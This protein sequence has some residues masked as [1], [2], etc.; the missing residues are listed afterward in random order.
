MGPR[1]EP[2][3]NNGEIM[4]SYGYG[5]NATVSEFFPS[6]CTGP[7]SFDYEGFIRYNDNPHFGAFSVTVFFLFFY[8]EYY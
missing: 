3:Q 2:E 8:E 5:V 7:R 4:P 6:V 1:P